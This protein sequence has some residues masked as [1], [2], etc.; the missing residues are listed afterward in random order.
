MKDSFQAILGVGPPTSAAKFAEFDVQKI[1]EELAAFTKDG[2]KP[3]SEIK[4][5]VQHYEDIWKHAKQGTSVIENLRFDNMSVCLGSRSGSKGH[6]TWNDHRPRVHP[7]R[8]TRLDVVGDYYWSLA[9]SDA[10]IGTAKVL[11][12]A[13]GIIA[14]EVERE[15]IVGCNGIECSA[16]IDTGTTFIM[17]PP[18]VVSNIS[19]IID[20]WLDLGG[21]CDDI[22]KLP[23]L[24]FKL[25]GVPFSLPPESYI[26]TLKGSLLEDASRMMPHLLQ[27]SRVGKHREC[28]MLIMSSGEAEN[29]EMPL[30]VLGMPFFRKYYTSF[31]YKQRV[32]EHPEAVAMS[33]SLSDSRCRPSMSVASAA[34][35]E[36][37]LAL[38]PKARKAQ[39]HV[40]ASKIRTPKV[41]SR[42]RRGPT[43]KRRQI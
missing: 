5:N 41:V 22:S 10:R 7:D 29:D 2:S 23:D 40:D 12:N 24:E 13:D 38:R 1:H 30:W 9:I 39:M 35:Q 14:D 4:A 18:S 25:N 42:M 6:M 43:S 37:F 15:R 32:G 31:H 11:T 19:S 21:S 27:T 36:E 3:T 20:G 8:F 33:F 34:V 28:Q 16:V 17:A 26:G